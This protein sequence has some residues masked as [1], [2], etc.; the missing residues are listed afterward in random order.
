M[1]INVSIMK[2]EVPRLK[3]HLLPDE[4][5]TVALDCQFS[6]GV[7]APLHKDRYVVTLPNAPKTLFQYGNHWMA[8]ESPVSAINNP[9]AQDEWQRVYWTGQGKPKVTAQDIAL[10][11]KV[12]N[13]W[14]D[15]GV[16]RPSQ[17][18][19]IGSIDGSTGE[20]PP[21]G[22]PEFIDDEDRVYIQTYVTRFGEEGAPGE[23]SGAVVVERPGASVTVTLARPG[24]NTH[25][26]THTRLYRS[27]SSNGVGDYMLVAELPI[28]QETY[29]DSARSLNNAVLETWDYAMPDENMAGLCQMANGICAG[30]A[31]N[32]VMFSEAYLPYAWPESYRGT[33]AHDI[34]AITAIETSLVVVT[35]GYPYLFSGVTPS[36]VNGSKLNIEQGCVS[37]DSLVV[38]NG[39]A[40]YASPDGIVAISGGSAQLVTEPLITREQ[41]EQYNPSTIRA[42][43]VEGQYVALYDGGG[44]VFDPRSQSFTQISNTWDCAFNDLERDE[45]FI[46]R[47]DRLYAWKGSDTP[48]T[49]CWQSKTF[50]IPIDAPLGCARIQADD[51][52]TIAVTFYA[53]GV[54]VLAIAAGELDDQP[55][56]LPS[57]RARKW[58][59]AV[60]GAADIDRILLA[61]SM[62]E[63][64]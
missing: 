32:E 17:P 34:V 4:A 54:P 18:P 26:I 49:Y 37:A 63:L 35:K 51:P 31:G 45:L 12:P 19:I 38:V 57:V 58:S 16:P 20:D 1:L 29:I 28:S 33:T 11:T 50:L 39:V 2:G 25:N 53:D 7:V 14:Y 59:V 10:G 15:L 3:S 46:A 60:S 47:G 6:R 27:V 13:A 42:W 21:E 62:M 24:S 41:W 52:E 30:F 9:M 44:F 36:A 23:P 8:F 22:E 61:H 64:A 40:M 55:F 56:R 5:A 48:G 43:S